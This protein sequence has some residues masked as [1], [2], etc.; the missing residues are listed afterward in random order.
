MPLTIVD[1][2]RREGETSS[3]DSSRGSKAFSFARVRWVS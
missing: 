1:E 3:T 2:M